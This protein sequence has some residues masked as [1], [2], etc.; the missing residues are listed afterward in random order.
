[1][2]NNK[3]GELEGGEEGVKRKKNLIP[4]IRKTPFELA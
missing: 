2:V 4:E 1:V 3:L